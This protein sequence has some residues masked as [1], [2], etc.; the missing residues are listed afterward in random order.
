MTS[1]KRCSIPIFLKDRPRKITDLWWK[2]AHQRL[3]IGICVK[4]YAPEGEKCP[5]C[6]TTTI[7]ITHLFDSCP[8]TSRVWEKAEECAAFLTQNNTRQPIKLLITHL[9]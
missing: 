3:P 7:T 1:L 6:I 2:I 5:W 8:Y 9:Y 4:Q